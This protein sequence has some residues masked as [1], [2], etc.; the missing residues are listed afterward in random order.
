VR[1][2]AIRTNLANLNFVVIILGNIFEAFL[3]IR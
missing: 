2:I 1:K 3:K